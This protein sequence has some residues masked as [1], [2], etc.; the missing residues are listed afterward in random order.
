MTST[1]GTETAVH[2]GARHPTPWIDRTVSEQTRHGPKGP[3]QDPNP[4]LGTHRCGR[5][6]LRQAREQRVPQQMIRDIKAG[7]A[8][9]LLQR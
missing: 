6:G 2:G 7:E 8:D 5:N 1:P 3:N 4:T 9:H